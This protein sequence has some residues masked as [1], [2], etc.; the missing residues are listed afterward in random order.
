MANN[1]EE[2]V[3]NLKDEADAGESFTSAPYVQ[4]DENHYGETYEEVRSTDKIESV[5]KN[6]S[7]L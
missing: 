2:W 5:L 6:S 1:N 3:I 4:P 7:K